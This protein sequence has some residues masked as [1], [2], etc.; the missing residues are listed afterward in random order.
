MLCVND[1]RVKAPSEDLEE[2]NS[3]SNSEYDVIVSESC[4]KRLRKPSFRINIYPF[5]ESLSFDD[6]YS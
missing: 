2:W 6:K 4:N 5:I 1:N 3:T